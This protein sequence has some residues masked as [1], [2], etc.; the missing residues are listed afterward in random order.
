[1]HYHVLSLQI[2]MRENSLTTDQSPTKL[3]LIQVCFEAMLLPVCPNRP[4]TPHQCRIEVVF[5]VEWTTYFF[6][7]I[8]AVEQMLVE[9]ALI[10][11]SVEGNWRNRDASD[12]PDDSVQFGTKIGL[13]KV[14]EGRPQL[15]KWHTGHA[16]HDQAD[17]P[18]TWHAIYCVQF[19]QPMAKSR[20]CSRKGAL[21]PR[22]P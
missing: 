21:D 18:R 2:G 9:R 5:R 13:F 17:T 6:V 1:M 7:L 22:S 20:W 3:I 11:S 15:I 14:I 19:R 8:G 12:R 10:S 16:L 4:E